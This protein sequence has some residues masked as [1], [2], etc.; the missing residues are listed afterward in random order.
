MHFSHSNAAISA[1]A[2]FI[3][4]V[5]SSDAPAQDVT[6]AAGSRVQGRFGSN[7]DHC[8]VVGDRR[9]TGGYV[10]RCDAKPDQEFVFAASDV[11]AME[12]ADRAPVPKPPATA[13]APANAHVEQIA[14]DAF[15]AIPP[16]TGV[17]GCMDQDGQETPGL[18]FGLV[19]ASTYS[20]YDG[21]GGHYTYSEQSGVLVFT[22]GPFAGLRRSRET[23]R[24]FRMLDEHGERTAFMCPWEPK[25]PHK[26]HW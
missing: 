23:E 10:L 12:G 26:L 4:S 21:G 6:Y 1:C 15:K 3:C 17:Y 11:R 8:T 19:N 25:D 14:G 22:S 5:M 16:R 13:I 20:T 24:S 9:A 18:Q 7:W 2:I